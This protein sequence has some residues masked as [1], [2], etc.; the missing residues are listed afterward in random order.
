MPRKYV[1]KTN[2]RSREE[3]NLSVRAVH[4]DAPDL[5]KLTEL[6]IRFTLQ[7][8]GEQRATTSTGAPGYGPCQRPVV[9]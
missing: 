5:D 8:A 3:R 1:R 9:E 7:D 4:R 2:R 6:L